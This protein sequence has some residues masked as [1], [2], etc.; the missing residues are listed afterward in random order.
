L[1]AYENA[2]PGAEWLPATTNILGPESEPEPDAC[3]LILPDCGGQTK[4]LDGYL[5]GAP[6]LIAETAATTES[7]DLHQKKADY[8]KAGVREYVV[9]ALR[10]ER[11]FW[12]TLRGGKYR[13]LK[14]DATAS[15]ARRCFRASGSTRPRSC[16]ATAASSWRCCGAG[17][18]ARSIARLSRS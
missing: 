1:D 13:E 9:V 18:R 7:R 12:F 5:A 11:V 14:S 16:A 2:T 10:S 3:L 17:W 4:V 8:E 15:I 6:E